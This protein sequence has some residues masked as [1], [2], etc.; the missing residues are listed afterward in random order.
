MCHGYLSGS[1]NKIKFYKEKSLPVKVRGHPLQCHKISRLCA[2]SGTTNLNGLCSIFIT[3]KPLNSTLMLHIYYIY[4]FHILPFFCHWWYCCMR[5]EAVTKTN[6][7]FLFI[8]KKYF[9]HGYWRHSAL[10]K[11]IFKN[12]KIIFFGYKSKYFISNL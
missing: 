9:L 12:C 11:R 1:T 8:Q 10:W 5:Y 6:I 7:Q 3:K 2:H 4:F